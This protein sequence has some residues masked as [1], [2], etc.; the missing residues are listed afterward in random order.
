MTVVSIL[1]YHSV[2][3]SPSAALRPFSLSPD[4]FRSH[5][6][7][8]AESGVEALSVSDYVHR[9]SA[10]TLPARPAVITFDDGFAD[11]A[12]H[13]L[14]VLEERGLPATLFV[15]TGF[16]EGCPGGRV[17]ARPDDPMLSWSQLRELDARGIE[18]GA[19]THGHPH[20]DTLSPPAARAEIERSKAL[21]EN[22]LGHA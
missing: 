16:L 4:A 2:S 9:R 17:S 8:I 18:L 10:G 6:D 3:E 7:A 1:L 14:P 22:E 19:H 13:A 15:T 12:E 21:L 5:A 11:F 20:L